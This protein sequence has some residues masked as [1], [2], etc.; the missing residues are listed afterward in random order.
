[1]KNPNT[2]DPNIFYRKN[3]QRLL[4]F[5]L[6]MTVAN[7]ILGAILVYLAVNIPRPSTFASFENTTSPLA[8]LSEPIVSQKALLEWASQAAIS[9]YNVDYLNYQKQL[10]AN[11]NYFSPQGWDLFQND[12]RQILS[13]IVGQKLRA[14]AVL[15]GPPV[16]IERGPLLGRYS[17]KIRM[18]LLITYESASEIRSTPIMVDMLVMRVSTLESPKG[19]AITQFF[20]REGTPRLGL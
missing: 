10:A 18:P 16:I 9:V 6:I 20:A 8:P 2:V 17:W 11:A 19:I 5:L 7:L 1:M 14:S 3:Y 4:R 15:T 12:F 13:T